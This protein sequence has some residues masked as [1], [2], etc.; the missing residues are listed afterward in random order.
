MQCSTSNMT[1]P[2]PHWRNDLRVFADYDTDIVVN[3]NHRDEP[4]FYVANTFYPGKVL[5]IRDPP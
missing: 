2:H 3:R 1:H 5:Y 4:V